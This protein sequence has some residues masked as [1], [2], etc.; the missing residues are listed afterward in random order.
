[1]TPAR[2][3]RSGISVVCL[4]GVLFACN[5]DEIRAYREPRQVTKAVIPAAPA[6]SRVIWTVPPGWESVTS[7]QAM[8]LA[9]FRPGPD[10]PEVTLAAFPGDTG[11]LLANINRWRGQVGLTPIDEPQLAKTTQ[12]STVEGVTITTVELAGSDGQQMLGAVVVPGDGQTWFVKTTGDPAAIAR[13]KTAFDA[14]ARSFRLKGGA[15]E[16]ATGTMG[17]GGIAKVEGSGDVQVRLTAWKPPTHWSADPEASPI[18]A[19]AYNAANGEGGAKIT[20]TMLLNDGG[21]V[22]SNINRWRDQLGLPPVE[23]LDQEKITDL[24]KGSMIVDLSSADG[25]RRMLSAIVGA[26]NQTWFFKMTGTPKG[27]EAERAHYE[28][29]VRGVGLGENPP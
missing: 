9:T 25:T 2:E 10:L 8:R 29:M 6:S 1:M 13:I 24:G 11:G 4:C 16:P 18:V 19:A 17:G 14:F 12:T 3:L 21:G 7:D 27:V 20:A 15:A 23:R 26:Q 5:D 28:R 22:L